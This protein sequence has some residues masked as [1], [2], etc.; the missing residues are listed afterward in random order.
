[1]DK[2][3]CGNCIHLNGEMASMDYPYPTIWCANVRHGDGPMEDSEEE[4]N[5]PDWCGEEIEE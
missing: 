2:K 3:C 5:C 1:M 4:T